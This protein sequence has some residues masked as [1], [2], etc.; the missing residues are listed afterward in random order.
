MIVDCREMSGS[1]RPSRDFAK[2]SAPAE[3]DTTG[4]ERERRRAVNVAASSSGPYSTSVEAKAASWN[5]R[6]LA[7]S[8]ATEKAR[9]WQTDASQ[10]VGVSE[11]IRSAQGS[12][13]LVQVSGKVLQS[14]GEVQRAVD[15]GAFHGT[16]I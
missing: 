6:F 7:G 5:G 4:S 11:S 14:F 2:T 10:W 9:Y 12:H 16:G 8:V 13:Q 1:G 15:A 3:L